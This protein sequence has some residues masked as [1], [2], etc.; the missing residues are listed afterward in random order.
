MSSYNFFEDD[1]WA[2]STLGID[3]GN[4][5]PRLIF[6]RCQ[7]LAKTADPVVGGDPYQWLKIQNAKHYLLHHP[8]QKLEFF[9]QPNAQPDTQPNAKTETHQPDSTADNEDIAAKLAKAS[10]DYYPTTNV[11]Q[12]NRT[13]WFS[14]WLSLE[15]TVP[16]V[17][18]C[19][20][21]LV[22][23]FRNILP[24]R[25]LVA[26]VVLMMTLAL[27]YLALVNTEHR[28]KLKAIF[29]PDNKDNTA[30]V[31]Y[32]KPT[33]TLVCLAITVFLMLSVL[34]N[35]VGA[36]ILFSTQVSLFLIVSVALFAYFEVV[37]MDK[38]TVGTIVSIAFASIA[39]LSSVYSQ[40]L[41]P[42]AVAVLIA[43]EVY[44][45]PET[46]K[47]DTSTPLLSDEMLQI[48]VA[49]QC[50]VLMFVLFRVTQH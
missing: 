3:K 20:M 37:S 40:N 48:L 49:L 8:D 12:I 47:E 23:M 17:L 26:L 21:F 35:Y 4:A 2:Y 14:Y 46:P 39:V 43:F 36:D 27:G 42:V 41:T 45:Y 38:E 33:L 11:H 31:D 16:T 9:D 30:L 32:A 19:L 5:T 13:N 18:F 7:E 34:P 50:L 25:L 29:S 44:G 22:F 10:L 28:G 6:A 24:P 15:K 1:T